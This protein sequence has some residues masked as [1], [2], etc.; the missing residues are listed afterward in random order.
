MVEIADERGVV[1]GYI[2]EDGNEVFNEDNGEEL[3]DETIRSFTFF[4]N[5]DIEYSPYK[6]TKVSDKLTP[7]YYNIIYDN[8]NHKWEISRVTIKK[9]PKP[10]NFQ[11]KDILDKYINSLVDKNIQNTLKNLKILTKGGVLF[12]GQ[13]GTGKSTIVQYYCEQLVKQSNAMVFYLDEDSFVTNWKFLTKLKRI[14]KDTLF[15]VVIEE[16]DDLLNT[17]PTIE[18]KLK[19]ILD[20]NLS[21]NNTLFFATTNYI[22]KIP[23]ALK[24]RPSRF[25]YTFE[26]DALEDKDSIRSI[27]NNIIKDFECDKE[28]I[29]NHCV[30]KTLDYIQNYCLDIILNLSH[31]NFNQNKISL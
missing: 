24:N 18:D 8:Y 2:D 12:Y 7:G 10:F 20:G 26:I 4:E 28:E 1:V 16:I 13:E 30:G 14:H 29:V 9:T 22:H 31:H 5:G 23:E 27:V 19:S 17:T 25:K 6:V 3:S 21:L 15:I 11:N